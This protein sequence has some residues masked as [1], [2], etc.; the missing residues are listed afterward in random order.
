MHVDG[1]AV[2]RADWRVVIET[3]DPMEYQGGRR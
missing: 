2:E 1:R 3:D